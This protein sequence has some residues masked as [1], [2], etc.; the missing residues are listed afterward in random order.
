MDTGLNHSRSTLGLNTAEYVR[1]VLFGY[2]LRPIIAQEGHL[3]SRF[4]TFRPV[5]I[6]GATSVPECQHSRTE[7][8]SAYPT[9]LDP[10]LVDRSMFMRC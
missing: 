3:R 9:D 5:Q 2:L 1:L 7:M 6:S 8:A 4:S 10:F